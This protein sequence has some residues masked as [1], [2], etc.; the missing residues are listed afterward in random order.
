MD[1]ARQ[2]LRSS[3]STNLEFVARS[4]QVA[5]ESQSRRDMTSSDALR[6]GMS[7]F[8]A[9]V[10]LIRASV[11]AGDS[12]TFVGLERQWSS[13]LDDVWVDGF[14]HE[15]QE[16]HSQR[17]GE[18]PTNEVLT[19]L[20]RRDVLRFALIGWFL[21][22]FDGETGPAGS[23]VKEQ[24][25][26]Q[27]A[28]RFPSVEWVFDAYQAALDADWQS[29][30][31]FTDW[32]LSGRA[33][34]EAHFIPTQSA[35]LRGALAL[36]VRFITDDVPAELQ[37]REWFETRAQDIERELALLRSSPDRWALAMGVRGVTTGAQLT[38]S[39]ETWLTKCDRLHTLLAE[40][41]QDQAHLARVEVRTTPIDRAR[42][43]TI[44]DAAVAAAKD[45]GVIRATFERQ[46]AVDHVSEKPAG[47]IG[48]RSAVWIPREFVTVDSR[49]MAVDLVG[50]DLGGSLSHWE[51]QHLVQMLNASGGSE[52]EPKNISRELLRIISGMRA[53]GRPPSLIVM[54][55]SWRLNE[56]LGVERRGGVPP[57]HPLVPVAHTKRF[58][59]L[60]DDVPVID[61]IEAPADRL[62][63]IDLPSAMRMVEWPSTDGSGIQIDIEAFDSA[64]AASAFVAAHSELVDGKN[65]DD[66]VEQVQ[67]QVLI[68]L[69]VCWLISLQ[70]QDAV[71]GVRVPKELQRE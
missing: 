63:V 51:G 24:A 59:G 61:L 31:P 39:S 27:I 60:I 49:V 38:S 69:H 13:I 19:L 20:R 18:P 37:P 17:T 53:V 7:L 32:F 22:T 16:G 15:G 8:D 48:Y 44:R 57:L 66:V 21:W 43:R 3:A 23:S 1:T 46:G 45:S 36:A 41:R 30:V 25:I 56:N 11:D 65:F 29:S 26:Q 70:D 42:I 2:A 6:L 33:T 34:G 5:I 52:P 40:A 55:M 54:P 64:A 58:A 10:E 67:D 35:F 12:Q 28:S 47:V 71:T 50:R 14:P 68:T 9:F 62:W 4:V